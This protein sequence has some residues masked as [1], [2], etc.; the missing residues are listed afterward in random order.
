MNF[1]FF[2]ASSATRQ[3]P[4]GVKET[5]KTLT[6]TRSGTKKMSVGRH[7]GDRGHVVER[8]ENLHTGQREDNEDYINLA[9]GEF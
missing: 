9:E 6:D 3:A 7:L 5:R 4:G 8:E 1:N 2:Q